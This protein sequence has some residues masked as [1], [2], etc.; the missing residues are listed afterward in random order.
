VNTATLTVAFSD[1]ERF[2]AACQSSVAYVNV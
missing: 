2:L 1:F